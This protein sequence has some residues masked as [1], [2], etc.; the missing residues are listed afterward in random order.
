M[1]TLRRWEVVFRASVPRCRVQPLLPSPNP[2]ALEGNSL[3]RTG[4]LLLHFWQDSGHGLL[5]FRE[6]VIHHSCLSAQENGHPASPPSAPGHVPAHFPGEPETG[7]SSSST[8]GRALTHTSCRSPSLF[9]IGHDPFPSLSP[10]P[11]YIALLRPRSS[12]LALKSHLLVWMPSSSQQPK[13]S[14][15]FRCRLGS[16][17]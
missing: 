3:D 9:Y 7:R 14:E 10:F 11:A 13:T 6:C 16:G 15:P 1:E 2:A 8:P 17:L 5:L 12:A 4:R